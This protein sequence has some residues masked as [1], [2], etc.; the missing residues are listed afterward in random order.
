MSLAERLKALRKEHR[1]TLED[2]SAKVGVGRATIFKY[3]NGRITNIPS[4]KIAAM[5]RLFNVS[6]AYLMGWTDD[7]T[8]SVGAQRTPIVVPNS[9]LFVEV[10]QHMSCAD[11][12]TVMEIFERTHKKMK[13]EGI[14][15]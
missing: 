7:K 15:E 2:V 10:V 5:A 1:M 12:E 4:D 14:S 13:E 9:K 6:P 11:Y 3:E 8:D